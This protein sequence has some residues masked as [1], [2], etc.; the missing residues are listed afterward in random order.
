MTMGWSNSGSLG[1]GWKGCGGSG[2]FWER[3]AA[4]WRAKRDLA[5]EVSPMRRE[6]G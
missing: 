4:R 6:R 3:R 2:E 1:A 5:V